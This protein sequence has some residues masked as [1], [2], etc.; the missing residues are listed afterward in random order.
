MYINKYSKKIYKS[1]DIIDSNEGTSSKNCSNKNNVKILPNLNEPEKKYSFNFRNCVCLEFE[2][3]KSTHEEEKN[4]V[5]SLWEELG[6]TEEYKYNF[7]RI[8]KSYNSYNTSVIFY[9]EKNN[10][11]KFKTS[12]LKLK[13]EI[14][15]RETNITNLK[16]IIKKLDEKEESNTNSDLIN[17][18]ISIIKQLRLNAINIVIYINRVRELS[19]YYYFQG[20]FDLT[21]IKNEY[22]YDN[23]YLLQM[24][25]DLNFLKNSSINNYINF[26]NSPCD[27]FLVNCSQL[28]E[29]NNNNKIIIPISDD[30]KQL[31]EQ[32]IFFIFQDKILDNIYLKKFMNS[33]K[34]NNFNSMKKSN[35]M[36]LKINQD[37]N[38]PMTSKGLFCKKNNNNTK[39]RRKNMNISEF[40]ND[41]DKRLLNNYKKGNNIANSNL[42]QISSKLNEPRIKLLP[43]TRRIK[44]R[45]KNGIDICKYNNISDQRKIKIYNEKISLINL[46]GK[47]KTYMDNNNNS[48]RFNKKDNQIQIT[49]N[50]FPIK[51]NKKACEKDKDKIRIIESNFN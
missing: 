4:I 36:I 41:F 15:S 2:N 26:G 20:K 34:N 27:A 18:I 51:L 46:T 6:I 45:F 44:N 29:N 17:E 19:F 47:N 16:K 10:L 23:N 25:H 39:V 31:I 8:L 37:L 11:E 48:N 40:M 42:Y 1:C 43:E 12:L 14:S 35:S 21:K 3:S 50:K 24:N 30:I 9:Q 7:N 5:N 32:S 13:K 33:N 28:N 49:K 22:I 38:R